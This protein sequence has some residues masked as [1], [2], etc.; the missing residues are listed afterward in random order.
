MKTFGV[1]AVE[2]V[3]TA[4]EEGSSSGARGCSAR[5]IARTLDMMIST[6]HEFFKEIF[7]AIFTK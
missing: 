1:A 7:N 4:L 5:G 2:S 3:T 6:L